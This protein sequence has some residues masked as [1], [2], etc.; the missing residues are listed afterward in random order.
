MNTYLK[1]Y[2]EDVEIIGKMKILIK[3][4]CLL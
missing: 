1:A 2:T 4:S 3:D